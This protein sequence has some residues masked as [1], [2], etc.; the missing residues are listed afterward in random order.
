MTDWTNKELDAAYLLESGILFEINR[1]ILHP[2]GISLMV[3]KS[4]DGKTNLSLRDNRKSP[5][6]CLF[7][8]VVYENGHQK[9]RNFVRE[10][11]HSQMKRRDRLLGWSSQ[12]L[13]VPENKR[14]K[15]DE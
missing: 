11:G 13:F 8:K 15:E 12:S 9:L 14:Y 5:E 1:A 6:S 3:K 7:P 10:F 4:E 2:F